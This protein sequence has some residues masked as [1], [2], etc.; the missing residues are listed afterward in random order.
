MLLCL[1]LRRTSVKATLAQ[2]SGWKNHAL[3]YRVVL[4]DRQ[5]YS[6][7]ELTPTRS[8][9]RSPQR[10]SPP[11][12]ACL[13][14]NS[15]ALNPAQAYY[16]AP[17]K[18]GNSNKEQH[19]KDHPEQQED[20]DLKPKTHVNALEYQE[21]ESL[22]Y[23]TDSRNEKHRKQYLYGLQQHSP[24]DHHHHHTHHHHHHHQNRRQTN[25][26]S[27]AQRF[28]LAQ[29]SSK[30][31]PTVLPQNRISGKTHQVAERMKDSRL[32]GADLYVARLG[33]TYVPA[34]SKS[35]STVDKKKLNDDL[36]KD[37]VVKMQDQPSTGSLHD[38]L[39]CPSSADDPPSDQDASSSFQQA[40][41][42][43][44]RPC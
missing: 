29:R 39:R 41:A 9:S 6:A 24:L 16:A 10:L 3:N 30:S 43:H 23:P 18:A 12:V 34:K 21:A 15:R 5:D 37:Q 33:R 42:T 35:S 17:Y 31:Q 27:L 7:S 2:R 38:E 26:S 11:P 25:E 1:S 22:R 19:V 28:S 8:A 40:S 44:S 14:F 20:Q 36:P 4:N 32:K 13:R